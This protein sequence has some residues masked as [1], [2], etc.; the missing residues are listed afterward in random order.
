MKTFSASCVS[1]LFCLGAAAAAQQTQI[2]SDTFGGYEARAI[3]PA[4]M[5][6]RI[7]DIDAVTDNRLTIYAGSASGGL[8]KS[9]DA[10]ITFKPMFD[11]QPSLSIGAV[12]I[13]PNDPHG[14]PW[15]LSWRMYPNKDHPRWKQDDCCGCNCGCVAPWEPEKGEKYK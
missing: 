1:L 7:A 15:L 6:G 13:D 3:G 10:G 2:D 14:S 4:A 8:W 11:K 12:K 9:S 5:G